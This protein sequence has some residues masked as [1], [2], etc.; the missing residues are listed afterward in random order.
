MTKKQRNKDQERRYVEVFKGAFP[1]FPAGELLAD[2]NQERPDVI[3]A[4]AQGNIGIE[5][6]RMLHEPMKREESEGQAMVDEARSLYEKRGLP[7][8]HVSVFLGARPAFTR[9]N[10]KTFAAA[11]AELVAANIPAA[12]DL[13]EL[14]NGWDAAD[15]FPFEIH[16]VSILRHPVLTRNYWTVPQAG[17]ILENFPQLLQ[18][19]IAKKEASIRGYDADCTALWLLVVAEH[20]GPSS[21]FAPSGATLARS[22][23][24]SF[25]RVFFLEL[26]QRKV[27]E[28][29]LA[30]RGCQ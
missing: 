12:N 10:R 27:F 21:F 2:E 23:D 16:S 7:N 29:K 28:L 4:N 5:V 19:K 6:T 30:E 3:V 17:W 14:E 13:A 11:L 15:V 18:E 1:G 8:L 20:R 25:D 22:Y 9:Q 26:L 24:S